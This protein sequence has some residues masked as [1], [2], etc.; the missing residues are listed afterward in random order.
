MT[1]RASDIVRAAAEGATYVLIH[2]HG[3]CG[4]EHEGEDCWCHPIFWTRE[5]M[6]NPY[7]MQLILDEFYAVQ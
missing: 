5:Q 4:L 7:G 1:V 3:D 2:R 6:L